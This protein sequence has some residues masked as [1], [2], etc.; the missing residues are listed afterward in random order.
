MNNKIIIPIIVIIIAIGI[1]Y[2]ISFEDTDTM[3][4]EDT[5]N[6]EIRPTEEV[7][8]E[9]QERLDEIEKT[10]QEN[11]YTPKPR[12]WITSGPFQIDRSE[13]VLG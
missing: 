9:I 6:K 12:E 3:E 11:E 2:A 13:Y 10:N 1:V 8:P 7:I 4:V 5:I